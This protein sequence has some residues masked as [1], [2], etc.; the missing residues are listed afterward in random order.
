MALHQHFIILS[1]PRSGST[2]LVD[3]LDAAPSVKCLSEIFN[4]EVVLLRHHRPSDAALTDRT[5]RDSDPLRFLRRLEEDVGPC[6]AFGVKLFPTHN[7]KLLRYFCASRRWKKIFLWRD[8]IVEQ[9]ISF[10]L[11]AAQYGR[12]SW[13]R[14]DDDAR[15]TVPIDTLIDDLHAMERNY[16]EIE[17]ALVLAE[18]EDVFTLEY[19]DMAHKEIMERLLR[20]VGVGNAAIQ[21]VAAAQAGGALAFDRGPRAADRIA[22][23]GDVRAILGRTRFARLVA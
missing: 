20:F 15:L 14:V 7:P 10:L 21:S 4:P 5:V 18:P 17:D 19:D 8:N 9:Y 22:N 3:Y 16:I 23:Y 6:D 11:A 2:Y 1:L 12:E 13:E